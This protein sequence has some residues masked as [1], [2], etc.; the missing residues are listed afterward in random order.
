MTLLFCL[1]SFFASATDYYVSSTGNDSANGLSSSTPWKTI[2]KVN[3]EFS[4]LNPGDKIL[5]RRGD[6][7][8]GTITISRSGTAGSPITISSYG[9]GALPRISGFTTITG[10]TSVGGGIYSKTVSSE[11]ISVVAFSPVR[12]NCLTKESASRATTVV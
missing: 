11:S 2:S 8:Y 12:V 7:F 5:F 4:R 3:S 6:V 1:C 9:T 10:W